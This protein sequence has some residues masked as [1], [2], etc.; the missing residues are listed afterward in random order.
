MKKDQKETPKIQPKV[1]PSQ[2]P[3][4]NKPQWPTPLKRN[5]DIESGEVIKR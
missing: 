2:K 1:N 4:P 5:E 3:L